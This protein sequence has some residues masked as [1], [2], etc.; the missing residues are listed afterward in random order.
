MEE[1]S[2]GLSYDT[3]YQKKGA[4]FAGWGRALCSLCGPFIFIFSCNHFGNL[5]K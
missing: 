4:G 2:L 1:E 5:E 3:E